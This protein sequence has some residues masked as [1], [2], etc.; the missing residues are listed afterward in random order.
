MGKVTIKSLGTGSVR[1]VT[2]RLAAYLTKR[3]GWVNVGAP[4]PA[5]PAKQPEPPSSEPSDD[6]EAMSYND[7]RALAIEAGV[8]PAGRKKADYIEALRYNRRDMRAED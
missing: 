2:P 3:G 8:E 7:V 1:N 4:E 5:R 6:L